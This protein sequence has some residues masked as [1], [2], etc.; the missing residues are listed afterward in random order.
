[1]RRDLK[2]RTCACRS[3]WMRCCSDG[4]RGAGRELLTLTGPTG[5]GV[6]SVTLPPP[7]GLLGEW[8]HGDLTS[9]VAPRRRVIHTAIY[10]R[11]DAFALSEQSSCQPR[12]SS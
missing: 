10:P 9:V 1:M 7:P 4:Q 2:T 5:A 11:T 8:G 3:D 12:Y 6:V